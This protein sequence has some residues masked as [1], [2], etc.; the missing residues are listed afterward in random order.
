MSRAKQYKSYEEDFKKKVVK[1]YENGKG[2]SEL[3]REYSISKSTINGWIKK[4]KISLHQQVKRQT[5]MKF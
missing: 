2:V 4:F 5:M 1:L 3:S